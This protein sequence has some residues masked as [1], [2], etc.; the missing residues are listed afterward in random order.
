MPYH[1]EGRE[2]GQVGTMHDH[3]VYAR[4]AP[5]EEI[6]FSVFYLLSPPH[7]QNDDIDCY[8]LAEV[9]LLETP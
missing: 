1:G 6:D 7:R 9:A 3:V 2:R 8:E 5:H 4:L